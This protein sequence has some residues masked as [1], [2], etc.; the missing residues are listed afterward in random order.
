MHNPAHTL[1]AELADVFA[2][3]RTGYHLCIEDGA[4]YQ[5]LSEN[6]EY[7]RAL[8]AAL[9]FHLSDGKDG[10]YYF[11]PDDEKLNDLSKRFTAFM[12]VM[13]D[14]LADKG[15]DPVSALTEDHYYLDQLPHLAIEQYQKVMGQIDITDDKD[16]FKIVNNLQKHGFLNL[17]DGNLIKFRKPVTRFVDLFMEVAERNKEEDA[18][19]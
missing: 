6:T 13:Y 1:P 15:K 4:T 11:Q 17:V 9:G 2:L 14:W 18:D 3:L 7:Y 5:G 16:L 19:E 12:A 8:F 10:L